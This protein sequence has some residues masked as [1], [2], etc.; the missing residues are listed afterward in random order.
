MK[1][2]QIRRV[3]A[4]V[5]RKLKARAAD[6]G[7]SLSGYLLRELVHL[8]ELPSREEMRARL[9][10]RTPVTLTPSAAEMIREERDRR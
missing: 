4:R 6:A 10:R 9:A 8:A 7:T 5:H 2:L 1:T 3:P